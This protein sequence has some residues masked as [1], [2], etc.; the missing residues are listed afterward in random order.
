[1]Y[2]IPLS[3]Q[4]TN[5]FLFLTW[6]RFYS[7]S[8]K[9]KVAGWIQ[10][11]EYALKYN[12]LAWMSIYKYHSNKNLKDYIHSKNNP[13]YKIILELFYMSLRIYIQQ[14]SLII[15]VVRMLSAWDTQM[16]FRKL[17][18]T[19]NAYNFGWY[20]RTL[21]MYKLVDYLALKNV[22]RILFITDFYE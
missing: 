21:L 8:W 13:N 5:V 11:Y 10:L 15:L 2:L 16:T 3:G 9:G 6:L 20:T 19:W 4:V 22:N 12:N 1:M 14:I 7:P 17:F 18:S